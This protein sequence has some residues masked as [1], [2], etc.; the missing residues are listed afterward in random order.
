M[1][2][3][4]PTSSLPLDSSIRQEQSVQS[5]E[6]SGRAE[7][8]RAVNSWFGAIYSGFFRAIGYGE[9][10]TV[11]ASAL[12]DRTIAASVSGSSAH[13]GSIQAADPQPASPMEL[14]EVLPAL[15]EAVG[16]KDA[17]R[18]KSLLTSLKLTSP[19]QAARVAEDNLKTILQDN[20]PSTRKIPENEY[21]KLKKLIDCL[22]AY[23]GNGGNA[24]ANSALNLFVVRGDFPHALS[25]KDKH[26]AILEA[27]HLQVALDKVV[28]KYAPYVKH[29][30]DSYPRFLHGHSKA[31]LA[32]ANRQDHQTMEIARKTLADGLEK[33]LRDT[34][35]VRDL[36]PK[37]FTEIQRCFQEFFNFGIKDAE[38]AY[39]FL[40]LFVARGDYTRAGT[41]A[42]ASIRITDEDLCK[43]LRDRFHRGSVKE[44]VGLANPGA[45]AQK[46]TKDT[47]LDILQQTLVDVDRMQPHEIGN[48]ESFIRSYICQ[49]SGPVEDKLFLLNPLIDFCVRGEKIGLA[50]RLKTIFKGCYLEPK[51]FENACEKLKQS[52]TDELQKSMTLKALSDLTEPAKIKTD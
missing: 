27:D 35:W 7:N 19:N 52:A 17:A 23:C 24:L 44:L 26:Q 4:H 10:G 3:V 18:V 38:L 6:T 47:V 31:I 33:C 2:P 39:S 8:G 42:S 20:F 41:I 40:N 45:A 34:Q 12:S 21:V 30:D 48:F 25:V 5:T 9:T 13:S 28:Q 22:L 1:Q 46:I 37:D 29:D 14:T 16:A 15:A 32:L 49:L 11:T 43:A 51:A 50:Q 36:P